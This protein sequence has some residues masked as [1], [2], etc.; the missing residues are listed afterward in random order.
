M[1]IY[2]S[3]CDT[4]GPLPFTKCTAWFRI[5]PPLPV[6]F[7][8]LPLHV[9]V[10]CIPCTCMY[11]PYNCILPALRWLVNSVV[12]MM[13]DRCMANTYVKYNYTKHV[14]YVTLYN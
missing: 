4:E 10:Q 7:L 14:E 13:G 11:V 1:N 12:L 9:H 8:H 5:H 3:G 6:Q 2:M